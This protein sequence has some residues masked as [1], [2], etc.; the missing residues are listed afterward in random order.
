MSGLSSAIS[1]N[2]EGYFPAGATLTEGTPRS[3]TQAPSVLQALNSRREGDPSCLFPAGDLPA[4]SA[5]WGHRGELPLASDEKED[6]HRHLTQSRTLGTLSAFRAGGPIPFVLSSDLS[7][8]CGRVPQQQEGQNRTRQGPSDQLLTALAIPSTGPRAE[9][10]EP[11]WPPRKQNERP[12]PSPPSHS[13]TPPQPRRPPESQM[14]DL[15]SLPP[16]SVQPAMS[17]QHG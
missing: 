2:T 12:T 13:E 9:C 10:L 15:T 16:K 1:V 3:T 6:L 11:P 8:S 17:T 7:A 5:T 4:T 14:E